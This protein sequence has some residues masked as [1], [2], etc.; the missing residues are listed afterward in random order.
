MKVLIAGRDREAM[1]GIL[2]EVRAEGFEARGHVEDEMV[3]EE[4]K[5][6]TYGVLAICDGV[7]P[8]SKVLYRQTVAEHSPE[9]HVLEVYAPETLLPG[10]V[11]LRA[12]G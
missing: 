9:T 8:D 2:D 11:D 3:V 5:T 7:D 4:L 6:G 1:D 10:L 12:N